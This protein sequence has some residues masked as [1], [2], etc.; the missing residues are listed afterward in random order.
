MS[1]RLQGKTC[2]ITGAALFFAGPAARFITGQT[3]WVD[4]GVFSR[5]AWPYGQ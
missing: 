5:A 1:G 2:L 3:L 4:G